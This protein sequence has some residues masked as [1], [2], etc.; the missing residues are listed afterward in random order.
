MLKPPLVEPDA[1]DPVEGAPNEN[2]PLFGAELV[3]LA[4]PA[5][6]ENEPVEAGVDAG[7]IDDEPNENPPVEGALGVDDVPVEEEEAPN[8]NAPLLEVEA[9]GAAAAAGAPKL[10]PLNAGGLDASGAAEGV[11]EGADDPPKA[12]GAGEAAGVAEDPPNE[13][14]PNAGFGAEPVELDAS[15]LGAGAG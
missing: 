7:F 2:P 8:W 11:L 5:P 3:E 10:N 12:K 9:E 4:V 1:A 13:K 15:A 6:N 14:P